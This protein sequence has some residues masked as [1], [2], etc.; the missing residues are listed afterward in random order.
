MRIEVDSAQLGGAA[1]EQLGVATALS[2]IAGRAAAAGAN[3]AAAG[4]PQ[5]QAALM[6]FCEHWTGSL[7][8]NADAIGGLGANVGTAASNYVTCDANAFQ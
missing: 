5:A 6:D 4:A 8:G 3:A 2:E 1:A 7:R